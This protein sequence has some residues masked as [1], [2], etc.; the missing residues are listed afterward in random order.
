MSKVA[1][2]KDRRSQVSNCWMRQP[3]CSAFAP[4]DEDSYSSDALLLSRNSGR[5]TPSTE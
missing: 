5:K 4:P 1:M 2:T 3:R